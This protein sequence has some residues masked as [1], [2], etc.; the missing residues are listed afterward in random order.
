MRLPKYANC[1][2]LQSPSVKI[3]KK[4]RKTWREEE[5]IKNIRVSLL[6]GGE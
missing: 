4:K 1:I 5:Q 6:R 3:E 2:Q